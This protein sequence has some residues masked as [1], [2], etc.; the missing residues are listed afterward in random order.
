VPFELGL[1]VS[2]AVVGTM[3]APDA[4]SVRINGRIF[5]DPRR[6][7]ALLP[8]RGTDT[9]IPPPDAPVDTVPSQVRPDPPPATEPAPTTNPPPAVP[10]NP[11]PPPPAPPQRPPVAT[12]R[13]EQ[14]GR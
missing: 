9:I 12:A 13:T 1:S 10:A 4:F 2:N 6:V 3:Q 11:P 14:G 7:R 5:V 8:G